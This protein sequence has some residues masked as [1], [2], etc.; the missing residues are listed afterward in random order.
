MALKYLGESI[1]IHGGGQDLIFPH[2][3]NEIAQS[4]SFTGKKPFARYWL[5]NGL[6]QIGDAKMSKSTG[7]LITIKE[8]LARHSAD[9]LRLFV[10]SSTYRS[11]LTFSEE[12]LEAAGR[13][14]ER[15]IQ[16]VNRKG[17]SKQKIDITTYQKQFL[18]AMDDDF[19]SARAI[20][21]LFDTA[22][23][24]NQAADSRQNID[25]ALKTF[26]ELATGVL[27]LRLKAQ[28]KNIADA[29]PIIELGKS[30]ISKISQVVPGL[31]EKLSANPPTDANAEPYINWLIGTR[32]KLRVAKQFK[33]ADEIRK[34]LLEQGVTLEDT[35]QGTT[36][37]YR[38]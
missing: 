34:K 6:L 36:W 21:S 22:H 26:K 17:G 18:E 11:P 3:E 23:A 8:I 25:D 38:K 27:G 19:N 33:L 35:P 37:K 28:E 20:S 1:D 4:E 13:G 10:L 29:G 16:T 15:L 5:H 7:N 32:T 9:T 2:H 30:I 31:S 12:G 14:I 24:I